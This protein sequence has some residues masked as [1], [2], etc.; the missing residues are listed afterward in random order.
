M[1]SVERFL[2]EHPVRL[3]QDDPSESRSGGSA[4]P[5]VRRQQE[6]GIAGGSI[7]GGSI[8]CGLADGGFGQRKERSESDCGSGP[9]RDAQGSGTKRRGMKRRVPV[10]GGFGAPHS[11]VAVVRAELED[12][13]DADACREAA[14]SLLDA[15]P[16]SS[17]ALTDRLVEKGYDSATV[18]QVIVRLKEL[19]LLDDDAYAQ[20]VIRS[21]ASR[22]M[23]ARGAAQE[24]SRKG[25]DRA[26]A[27]RVVAEASEAG[28][29]E[30][31]AWE[32]GRQVARR[33][34]GLDRDVR[35]RRFWSAGGRKGHAPDVLS[36]IAHELFQ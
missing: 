6:M 28:V 26:L 7:D 3:G 8:D 27:A 24:L 2:A 32:L 15:A 21:C 22:M 4:A 9:R 35:L 25:V 23:G 20:F 16:R 17:G 10:R 36:A 12:P 31:C 29:F 34:E 33:T 1:I 14:L 11:G 13:G 5:A 30:E 19:G 18:N